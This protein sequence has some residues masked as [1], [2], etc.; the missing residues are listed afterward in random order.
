VVLKVA[1]CHT[2]LSSRYLIKAPSGHLVK[3]SLE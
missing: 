3:R 2:A 1:I